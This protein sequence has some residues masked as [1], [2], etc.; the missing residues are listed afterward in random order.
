MAMLWEPPQGMTSGTSKA[1]KTTGPRM[2]GSGWAPISPDSTESAMAAEAMPAKSLILRP[3]DDVA[4][5]HRAIEADRSRLW[6]GKLI[7][8]AARDTIANVGRRELVGDPHVQRVGIAVAFGCSPRAGRRRAGTV[9]PERIEI[10][11]QP[12]GTTSDRARHGADA[13]EHAAAHR[14]D[15]GPGDRMLE[16][17][18]GAGHRRA[19]VKE[20]QAER[21]L[22]VHR[23]DARLPGTATAEH[24]GLLNALDHHVE[25]AQCGNGQP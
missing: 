22:A 7:G 15:R 8:L 14:A 18:R 23:V 3:R 19:E 2:T 4:R 25:R 12:T 20:T 13:G 17:R 16:P 1:S 24:G 5:D 6:L 10:P 11:Q 9:Q 21:H